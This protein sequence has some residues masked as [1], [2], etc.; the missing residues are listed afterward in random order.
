MEPRL[1]TTLLLGSTRYPHNSPSKLALNVVCPCMQRVCASQCIFDCVCQTLR[2]GFVGC[3][4]TVY[5]S[6]DYFAE[7]FVFCIYCRN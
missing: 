6:L 2:S 1:Y 5:F 3:V 4:R 7:F